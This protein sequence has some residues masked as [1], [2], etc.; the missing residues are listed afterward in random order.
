V[1]GL[2]AK[3]LTGGRAGVAVLPFKG[4]VTATMSC[5]QLRVLTH[6]GGEN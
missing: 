4:S 3:L 5:V 2:R 1:A 6:F